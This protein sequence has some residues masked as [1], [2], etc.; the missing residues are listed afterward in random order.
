MASAA[1]HQPRLSRGRCSLGTL[2]LVG[3]QLRKCRDAGLRRHDCEFSVSPPESGRDAGPVRMVRLVPLLRAV[4]NPS[5]PSTL[6]MAAC[7]IDA[8]RC[9]RL[10]P[11][12]KRRAGS[13]P[14]CPPRTALGRPCGS[15]GAR[16]APHGAL[17]V[18]VLYHL[19][20]LQWCLRSCGSLSASGRRCVPNHGRASVFG[21]S[22]TGLRIW[23]STSDYEGEGL[24]M[25]GRCSS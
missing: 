2:T 17:R 16:P 11:V 6:A 10:L 7:G 13:P 22:C 9:L 15:Q 3:R 24:R 5:V 25:T 20:A 4:W 21:S 23:T 12:G 18:Q 8:A 1:P 14:G 19:G